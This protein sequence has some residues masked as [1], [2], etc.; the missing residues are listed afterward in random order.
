M[1]PVY[2]HGMT[3]HDLMSQCVQDDEQMVEN[4]RALISKMS[5]TIDLIERCENM[6][7]DAIRTD[8]EE[9]YRNTTNRMTAE[10]NGIEEKLVKIH[11]ILEE[12][13]SIPRESCLE[14]EK[15]LCIN[16]LLPI[17]ARLNE[18]LSAVVAKLNIPRQTAMG[19]HKAHLAEL[20]ITLRSYVNEYEAISKQL[21]Q[22]NEANDRISARI[23]MFFCE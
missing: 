19:Y 6:T 23:N 21:E 20:S 17:Q 7:P 16:T 4:K 8:F 15:L 10:R 1:K 2:V 22:S 14:A 12:V 9:Y 18:S 13:K 11:E 5:Y 3:A